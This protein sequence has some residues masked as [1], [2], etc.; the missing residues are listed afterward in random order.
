MHVLVWGLS[1]SLF[2]CPL[3]GRSLFGLFFFCAPRS[4]VCPL[5]ALAPS[6]PRAS[7]GAPL[8]NFWRS[9]GRLL[10]QQRKKSN[11]ST[12][13]QHSQRI[14]KT[15]TS[16][17]CQWAPAKDLGQ[18]KNIDEKKRKGTRDRPWALCAGRQ[19]PL[20]LCRLFF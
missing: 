13:A 3:L 17:D 12:C 2:L 16:D 1:L 8:F 20:W 11:T 14:Y 10:A 18:S 9:A 7:S 6:L 19:S 15:C 5:F 4:F